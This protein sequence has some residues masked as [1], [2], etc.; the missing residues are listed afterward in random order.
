MMGEELNSSFVTE[1]G[2]LGDRTYAI[3]DKETSKVVS[4]KNPRKW[5]KL[6]DFR[7]AFIN[8]PDIDKDIP[9]VRVTFP[10]GTQI[11]SNEEDINPKLSIVLGREVKIV[12]S[13]M[14][15]PSY[16]EVLAKHRRLG[17]KRY[18]NRRINATQNIL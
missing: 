6:F 11:F 1:R 5:G 4:A 9:P 3:I 15:N 2:L 10:D 7:A 16:E 17:T 12:R 14:N 18:R 13:D 8:Q